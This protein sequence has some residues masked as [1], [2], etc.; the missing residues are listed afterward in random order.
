M[1]IMTAADP[2]R[3]DEWDAG[4]S[5]RHQAREKEPVERFKPTSGAFVGW[6]GLALAA[7]TLVWVAFNEHSLTGIRLALVAVFGAL[8]IWVTQFRPRV[9]AYPALMVMHGSLHDSYV[10]YAAI[11]EVSMGQT[12]NVWVGRRRYVCIGIGN[13]VGYEM[14]KRIRGHGTE[15]PTGGGRTYGFSGTPSAAGSEHRMSYPGFVLSRLDDLV[16]AS[17][18]N[19]PPVGQR[20]EVRR[21]LAVWEIGALA[22]AGVALVVSFLL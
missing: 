6:A 1:A 12:L 4:T 16:A 7:G 3:A 22:V 8:L 9:T 2:F 21:E 17:R 19:R 5:F 13:S 20:P 10:P 11:D 14:R 15:T 18:R